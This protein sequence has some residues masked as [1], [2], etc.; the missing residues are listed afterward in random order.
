MNV[1]KEVI[2]KSITCYGATE[3]SIICMEECG[4][5]IQAISKMLRGKN[6]RENLVEE[7]ADV[8][9]CLE[10]L[11]AVYL[12]SNDEIEKYIKY[13]DYRTKV[14]MEYDMKQLPV[15]ERGCDR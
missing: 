2:L 10:I 5:L 8:V 11:K 13:K 14:I 6:A 15:E 4:E 1:D 12:I 9:R 3:Q 7:M